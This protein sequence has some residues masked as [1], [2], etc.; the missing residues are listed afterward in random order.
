VGEISHD[1]PSLESNVRTSGRLACCHNG[2]CETVSPGFPWS[3]TGRGASGSGLSS[4]SRHCSFAH[5]QFH[6]A[7]GK[8]QVL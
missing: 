1:R 8:R 4:E 7:T 3:I 6:P 5:S 2:V